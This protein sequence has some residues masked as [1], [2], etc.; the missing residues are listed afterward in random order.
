MIEADQILDQKELTAQRNT[1]DLDLI[2]G[3]DIIKRLVEEVMEEEVDLEKIGTR[4]EVVDHETGVEIEIEVTE[5][6][7]EREEVVEKEET[8]EIETEKEIEK[9]EEIVTEKEVKE[10]DVI[11]EEIDQLKMVMNSLKKC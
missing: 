10:T 5:V 11:E 7:E 1:I 6:I 8:E 4:E 2:V 9:E 3:I